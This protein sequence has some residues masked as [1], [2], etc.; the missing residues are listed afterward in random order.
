MRVENVAQKQAPMESEGARSVEMTQERAMQ[1]LIVANYERTIAHVGSE[2]WARLEPAPEPQSYAEQLIDMFGCG[3]DNPK[4]AAPAPKEGKSSDYWLNYDILQSLSP[5]L[6]APER[7]EAALKIGRAIRAYIARKVRERKKFEAERR[8]LRREV[9]KMQTAWRKHDANRRLQEVREQVTQEQREQRAYDNFRTVLLNRGYELMRWSHS[10]KTPVPCFVRVDRTREYFLFEQNAIKRKRYAIQDIKAVTKGYQSPFLK[11]FI[12]PTEPDKQLSIYFRDRRRKDESASIDLIFDVFERARHDKEIS[13]G[14]SKVRRNRFFN[15]F[16]KLQRELE[17]DDAF[18]FNHE[19]VYCRVGKSVFDR[20]ERIT[21]VDPMWNGTDHEQR[22]IQWQRDKRA[23]SLSQLHLGRARKAGCWH[24]FPLLERAKPQAGDENNVISIIYASEP[25]EGD[26]KGVAYAATWY[27]RTI[28]IDYG[29]SSRH[30]ETSWYFRNPM[31]KEEFILQRCV[32]KP[33]GNFTPQF[34]SSRRR[35]GGSNP[36]KNILEPVRAR[37]LEMKPFFEEMLKDIYGDIGISGWRNTDTSEFEFEDAD[38]RK[39]CK[40]ARTLTFNKMAK[41]AADLLENAMKEQ[42]EAEKHFES[43]EGHVDE[44]TSASKGPS[45]RQRAA[46]AV[47]LTPWRKQLLRSMWREK[48]QYKDR[49]WRPSD[50]TY[51]TAQKNK[52]MADR[53]RAEKGL[54]DTKRPV[55]TPNWSSDL[56][57]TSGGGSSLL[58]GVSADAHRIEAAIAGPGHAD[59]DS[60]RPDVDS[61]FERPVARTVA[62]AIDDDRAAP[63][64]GKKLELAV[65]ETAMKKQKHVPLGIRVGKLDLDIRPL[66]IRGK[67]RDGRIECRFALVVHSLKEHPVPSISH[68]WQNQILAKRDLI[69]ALNGKTPESIEELIHL[70]TL[71]KKPRGITLFRLNLRDPRQDEYVAKINDALDGASL[72][73]I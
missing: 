62:T 59:V 36:Q 45:Q 57:Y 17:S 61:S 4:A 2:N 69:V 15:N 18:F 48:D 71:C 70:T 29:S 14:D 10:K 40:I 5:T 72:V 23:M 60:R 37:L 27:S 28:K 44:K 1:E 67:K 19:G 65:L 20:W 34:T 30:L 73:D 3:T 21:L 43:R 32:K 53:R 54:N 8:I 25:A 13:A 56:I 50:I 49:M 51:N 24:P 42:D 39:L 66:I 58:P 35:R 46:V 33:Q 47:D 68:A 63:Q 9:V 41:K 26:K 64:N 11:E 6:M 31:A 22:R 55:Y 16:S 38:W 52:V 7:Y 12:N